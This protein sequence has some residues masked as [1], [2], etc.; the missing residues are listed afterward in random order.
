MVTVE[1]AMGKTEVP[2]NPKRVVILT[3]EGTEA[4]LELGV[5]P[6]G[7]VKSWTGDPWYPHI[8]DKM[9]DVKVVGDEGQVNV[10]TIA[11]LKPDLII[12]NKMRHEKV[13]EQLKAIAPTVFS[14]TLRGEWKDNFKFYAKAL[15]KEKEGQKVVAD[16]ES[17]IKDLKG[18]LGDKV[19]QEISMVR[20]MP[21]DVRI[22]HGDTFSG[23]ILKELG[24]KRPGDQ[25]K[26]DFAE[27]NVS[28]ER[29]SAMDGDV[30]FYFTFDKGNEKKDLN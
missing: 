16:Y 15:N 24:F 27:R 14:E 28:K 12:G 30:L 1:H 8:K 9:K 6:V 20:F 11:S 25:N 17:R 23:V 18:K 10:E 13:Y 4:L 22:Y 26:D 19:N 29:I 5:K 7:A 2:A 3:N 21:G